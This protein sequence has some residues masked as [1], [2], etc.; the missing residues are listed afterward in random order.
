MDG[1][2]R[3][4]RRSKQKAGGGGKHLSQEARLSY[5]TKRN[6]VSAVGPSSKLPQDQRGSHSDVA[7]APATNASPSHLSK[8]ELR[9]L[10]RTR[11]PPQTYVT[12]DPKSNKKQKHQTI[13]RHKDRDEKSGFLQP[14]GNPPA[15]S[16]PDISRSLSEEVSSISSSK[17]QVEVITDFVDS[18]VTLPPLNTQPHSSLQRGS[19]H[20]NLLLDMPSDI[21]ASLNP[22]HFRRGSGGNRATPDFAHA[23][24]RRTNSD[25][26]F[27]PTAGLGPSQRRCPH[28]RKQFY[29]QFIKNLKY[30][31]I[32]NAV[33][34]R[35]EQQQSG[36]GRMSKYHSH[37]VNLGASTPVDPKSEGLWLE[38]RSKLKYCHPFEHYKEWLFF[39]QSEVDAVLRKVMH[40]NIS[41]HGAECFPSSELANGFGEM[42]LHGTMS[43]PTLQRNPAKIVGQAV[44]A[45]RGKQVVSGLVNVVKHSSSE[46]AGEDALDFIHDQQHTALAA[47]CNAA[48]SV[49]GDNIEDSLS[50]SVASS[51]YRSSEELR[52]SCKV[53][54]REYLSERQRIALNAVTELLDELDTVES[55]YMNRKRMGAKHHIYHT[56]FFKRRCCALILWQKVTYGLAENLCRLSNWLGAEILLPEV[57]KDSPPSQFPTI[58]SMSSSYQPSS[59]PLST[60]V[61]SLSSFATLQSGPQSSFSGLTSASLHHNH[62]SSS[63]NFGSNSGLAN[64]AGSG[65]VSPSPLSS[66]YRARFSVGAPLEEEVE[67]VMSLE[68]VEEMTVQGTSISSSSQSDITVQQRRALH[69]VSVLE[70]YREFVSRSLKRTG[71]SKTTKVN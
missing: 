53:H 16:I 3:E 13:Q 14:K 63:G 12:E 65:P 36:S 11:S 59:P 22:S 57:C 46:K 35:M 66:S 2:C 39:Q 42:P 64:S 1:C 69:Q 25:A 7:V 21:T 61:S 26:Q 54:H 71:L 28:E 33:T 19:H 29:R 60:R 37:S 41:E 6:E 5:Q 23:R 47:E 43:S 18:N 32:H 70:P 20:G 17:N 67:D 50:A 45:D 68:S 27:F 44:Q 38:I 15:S 9:K 56:L 30:H 55:F 51:F 8:K 62:G 49:R 24:V 40:F 34:N 58:T 4:K 52:S 31:G 48:E 10:T